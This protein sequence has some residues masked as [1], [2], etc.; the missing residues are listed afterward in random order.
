MLNSI[1]KTTLSLKCETP[2]AQRD[3]KIFNIAMRISFLLISFVCIVS[4]SAW[5][6]DAVPATAYFPILPLDALADT[7]PQL[8]PVASSHDLAGSHEG[9]TRVII[10][11]H[12]NNRDANAVLTTLSA[13]AGAENTSTMIIAP[14]FLLPSDIARF[15]DHLPDNGSP[16]A[17]WQL[18]GWPAGDDSITTQGRR[19]IS[20]FSVIDLFLMYVSDHASFPDLKTIIVVGYGAGANFVQRYAAFGLA[21]DAI[22]KQNIDLRFIVADA[23]SYLYLTA[24]RSLGGRKGFGV[25]DLAACPDYNSYPYGLDKLNPYARRVGVNAAKTSYALRFITYLNPA[26]AQGNTDSNCAA[27][28]QGGENGMRAL[29]YKSYLQSLFGDVAAS[30][31]TFTLLKDAKNDSIGLFSSSCGMEV[32]F[33]DGLCPHL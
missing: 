32:L 10:A 13:L 33:G 22:D 14:Q 19:G 18:T 31:Q 12:D 7:S 27:L 5:A 21:T 25:P 24:T 16:F 30:T 3:R 1:S 4:S 17:A 29:N 23:S 15:A 9:I 8:I 2:L 11:I 20:S 28:V 26:A 6:T